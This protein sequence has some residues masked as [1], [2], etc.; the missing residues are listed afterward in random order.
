MYIDTSL[1][2]SSIIKSGRM[3]L[4]N[5]SVIPQWAKII[6]KVL[7]SGMLGESF[8]FFYRNKNAAVAETL[9]EIC[10]SG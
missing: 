6:L 8:Q 7:I 10:L 3:Y 4:K 9:L 5:T 1:T 2:V